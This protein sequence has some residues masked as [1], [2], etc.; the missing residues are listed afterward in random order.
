[1]GQADS[2]LTPHALYRALGRSD[3]ERQAHYRALFRTEPDR[4]VVGDIR[5]A[6]NQNQPMGNERFLAK[7][8]AMTGVRRQA[9]PRGRPR[10]ESEASEA[11]A[12]GQGA[13]EL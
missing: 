6:I 4:A 5:L 11:P 3:T 2:R 9:R 13:L 1:M 12:V 10:L 7:I 8:E